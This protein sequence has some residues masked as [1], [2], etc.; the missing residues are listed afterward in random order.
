MKLGLL[1]LL[2]QHV[3]TNAVGEEAYLAQYLLAVISS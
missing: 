1:T 3:C 2:P